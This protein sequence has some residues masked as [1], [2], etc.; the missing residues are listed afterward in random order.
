MS[1]I[2]FFLAAPNASGNACTTPWSVI[3]TAG[4]PHC[5]A[6]LMRSLAEDTPSISLML[7]CMCSS[8]R[9]RS[10]VSWRMGFSRASMS[11]TIITRP[12]S[13]LSIFTSPRTANHLPGCTAA[14]TSSTAFF[15]S[16][17][18]GRSSSSVLCPKRPRRG[19]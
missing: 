7:V 4:C 11:S 14:M 15:S 16:S 18:G 19:L 10:A 12:C 8:M 1:L 5:A 3:A 9:L 13:K 17:V 2:L 6:R